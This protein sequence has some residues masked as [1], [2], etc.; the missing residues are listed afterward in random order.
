M[1]FVNPSFHLTADNL[2]EYHEK[3]FTKL[4]GFFSQELIQHMYE[5]ASKQIEYPKDDFYKGRLSGLQ[6]NMSNHTVYDLLQD[7]AFSKTMKALTE[8][9]LFF[10]HDIGF[11][12]AKNTDSGL[13]W[14]VG[15]QSFGYQRATDYGCSLW[16]P[17]IPIDNSK[18]KGGIA[19]ISEKMVSGEFIFKYLRNAAVST[20]KK[21]IQENEPIPHERF[22]NIENILNTPEMLEIL[23]YHQETFDCN[24][25][26][27]IIFN[28]QVIHKSIKLGDGPIDFRYAYVLRF[29]DFDA[30]Y[31]SHRVE[32]LETTRNYY[33]NNP[34]K[35]FYN[36]LNLQ[37]GDRIRESHFFEDVDNRTVYC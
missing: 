19:F 15:V 22:K 20:L 25:G 27:V 11:K 1:E 29:I 5:I 33:G 26:D 36:R 7:A 8:K 18:Q 12:I 35:Y 13:G 10:V 14:H 31:D 6:F 9:K 32:N 2:E 30:T 37:E 34:D 23:N 4:T 21:S 17:L 28:K 24:L 3:G 16:V